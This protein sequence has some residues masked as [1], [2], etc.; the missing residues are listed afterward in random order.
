[1][2]YQPDQR[3]IKIQIYMKRVFQ[4]EEQT[5][6]E[7]FVDEE[8]VIA[9]LNRA[10][11][12]SNEVEADFV[13]NLDE[14]EGDDQLINDDEIEDD[15]LVDYCDLKEDLH[16]E[17]DTN[18]DEQIY[19]LYSIFSYNNDMRY[20]SIH[21]NIIYFSLL[22]FNIIFICISRITDIASGDK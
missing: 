17:E 15:T 19:I 14:S 11:L 8:L 2:T 20:N 16:I 22:L 3:W 7:L 21:Q 10:D 6:A 4:K 9:S 1:M 18:I 13:F 12:P 5:L